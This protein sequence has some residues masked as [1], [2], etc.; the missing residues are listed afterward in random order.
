MSLEAERMTEQTGLQQLN[1]LEEQ[2]LVPNVERGL[3]EE[4]DQQGLDL[5][6]QETDLAKAPEEVSAVHGVYEKKSLQK[7]VFTTAHGAV[8]VTVAY[9]M[10]RGGSAREVLTATCAVLYFI[11]VFYMTHVMQER[12]MQWGEVISVGLFIAVIHSSLAIATKFSPPLSYGGLVG[13]FLYA[14]G[15]FLNTWSE[16]QRMVWKQLPTSKGRLYTEGLFKYSMHINYFGDLVLFSGYGLVSGRWETQAIPLVMGLG[17]VFQHIPDLDAYLAR[18]Y[19]EDFPSYSAR[20]AKLI[21][22]IW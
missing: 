13:F 14:V 9:F 10:L 5:A 19:P 6:Q 21:P 1:P 20:T 11:R 16:R 8:V 17:F 15:S 7:N 18:R 22:F 3:Q 12:K 4:L 2:Q